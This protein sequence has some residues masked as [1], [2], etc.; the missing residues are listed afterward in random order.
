MRIY[1]IARHLGRSSAE[2][3]AA[4]EALGFGRMSPSSRL[5]DAQTVAVIAHFEAAETE[6][7]EKTPEKTPDERPVW[8]PKI[9]KYARVR[10]RRL[11]EVQEACEVLGIDGADRHRLLDDAEIAALDAHFRR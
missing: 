11:V 2:V 8:P 6:T 3:A 5:T 9:Y 1:E 10:G 4:A 7:P